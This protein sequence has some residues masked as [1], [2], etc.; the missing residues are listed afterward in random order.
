MAFMKF[1]LVHTVLATHCMGRTDFGW[2]DI[3]RRVVL[4]SV[5]PHI[6]I[7]LPDPETATKLTK[8][9]GNAKPSRNT[10]RQQDRAR[11]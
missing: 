2:K 7:N 6:F 8:F 10:G 9:S 1:L 5:F 11:I 4:Q 3:W